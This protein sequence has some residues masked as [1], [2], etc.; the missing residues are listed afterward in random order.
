MKK[1]NAQ[2][3]KNL[4][5]RWIFFWIGLFF[6]GFLYLI[7]FLFFPAFNVIDDGASLQVSQ[8]LVSHLN[9]QTWTGALVEKEV[10]RFRPF[11][12]IWF[13]ILYFFFG[14][15][16]FFYWLPQA[17]LLGITLV[18]MVYF[19][20]KVSGQKVVSAVIASFLL[21]LG[22]TA[23]NYYRLG[24]AEPKQMIAG[25]LFLIWMLKQKG[26]EWTFKRTVVGLSILWTAF[27]FK[28]TSIVLLVPLVIFT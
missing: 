14:V 9:L 17:A 2:V 12:H 23:D 11:Y 7:P 19:L 15:R 28:E 4:K 6:L 22:V 21:L 24:T 27:L 20:W 3:H 10:G 1:K 18:L 8:K 25:L 13:L 5:N 16:P 26:K